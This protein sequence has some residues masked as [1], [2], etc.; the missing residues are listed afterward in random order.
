[1]SEILD[2]KRAAVAEKYGDTIKAAVKRCATVQEIA[3]EIGLPTVTTW[4][5]M[6]RLGYEAYNGWRKA[7]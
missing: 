1:M 2:V 3:A 7:R 6:R 4:R 5:I